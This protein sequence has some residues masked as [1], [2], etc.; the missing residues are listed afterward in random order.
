MATSDGASTSRM[1]EEQASHK[2]AQLSRAEEIEAMDYRIA[3]CPIVKSLL[4]CANCGT[5]GNMGSK[6]RCG[7]PHSSGATLISMSCKSCKTSKVLRIMLTDLNDQFSALPRDVVTDEQQAVMDHWQRL[8]G[9]IS[10]AEPTDKQAGKRRLVPSPERAE[11]TQKRI[12]TFFN[13]RP[14]ESSPHAP[15]TSA[16]DQETTS[17]PPN[18]Q[19]DALTNDEPAPIISIPIVAEDDNVSEERMDEPV[20]QQPT[21]PSSGAPAPAEL[22]VPA[23]SATASSEQVGE[24]IDEDY[25]P[26]GQE[27]FSDSSESEENSCADDSDEEDDNEQINNM[28]LDDDVATLPDAKDMQITKL[29]EENERLKLRLVDLETQN[30]RM[31]M[32]IANQARQLA[33]RQP[34]QSQP[35][36]RAA[37]QSNS[38]PAREQSRPTRGQSRPARDSSR[39]AAPTAA[40]PRSYAAAAK[41]KLTPAKPGNEDRN[42]A[43]RMAGKSVGQLTANEKKIIK[44]MAVTEEAAIAQTFQ[45]VHVKV[46]PPRGTKRES[47]RVVRKRMYQFLRLMKLDKHVTLAAPIG[48]TIYELYI[49]ERAMEKFCTQAELQNLT[50]LENFDPSDFSDII[51]YETRIKARKSAANRLGHLYSRAKF[52]NL[53]A[54]ILDGFD[55]TTQARVVSIAEE[56]TGERVNSW[57]TRYQPDPQQRSASSMRVSDQEATVPRASLYER[58]VERNIEQARASNA[59]PTRPHLQAP[60]ASTTTNS[61]QD[62]EFMTRVEHALM[63]IALEH[64]PSTESEL[65]LQMLSDPSCSADEFY[66]K[67]NSSVIV[68]IDKIGCLLTVKKYN[69]PFTWAAHRAFIL[70][71]HPAASA[72][73]SRHDL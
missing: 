54:A 5:T 1:A 55:Q 35:S 34:T 60:T 66:A 33:A 21:Q 27:D 69:A 45:R 10:T 46:R 22:P 63:E 40:G 44:R 11:P 53:R 49:C 28:D 30:A 15:T 72:V 19:A 12:N 31:T 24:D 71:C 68:G 38:R 47:P 59:V 48:R 16:K 26:S 18:T 32:R 13:S 62:R 29:I 42:R 37:T 23:P 9:L 14:K 70:S 56:L 65:Y 43:R 52:I 73:L 67:F 39:P 58:L 50:V 4:R 61:T 17:A 6:G 20:Q 36:S 7:N 25:I 57:R 41:S 3:T 8:N 64:L 51:E 2:A